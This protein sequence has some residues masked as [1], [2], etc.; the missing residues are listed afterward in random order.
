MK[1]PDR[2]LQRTRSLLSLGFESLDVTP[3][4]P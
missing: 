1:S 3:L 4:I 2:A